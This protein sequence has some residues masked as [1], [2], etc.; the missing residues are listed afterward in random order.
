[1][2]LGILKPEICTLYFMHLR[3]LAITLNFYQ[4]KQNLVSTMKAKKEISII[5]YM[6][7]E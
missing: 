3:Y 1:M 5:E 4:K 6:G 7:T 2:Y